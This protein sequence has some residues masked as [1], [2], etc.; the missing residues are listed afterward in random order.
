[1][2]SVP[3]SPAPLEGSGEPGW[4]FRGEHAS[5][6][7]VHRTVLPYRAWEMQDI[8]G[9]QHALTLLRQSLRYCVKAE[10]QAAR[11]PGAVSVVHNFGPQQARGAT[12]GGSGRAGASPG[13][14]VTQ[15]DIPAQTIHKTRRCALIEGLPRET[16]VA[17]N[18]NCP[19]WHRQRSSCVVA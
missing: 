3:A 8:V 17:P 14:G 4:R 18:G 2:E 10:P 9:T 1:M 13:G 11:V 7:E 12:G 5:L 6:P 15:P 16:P 19:C